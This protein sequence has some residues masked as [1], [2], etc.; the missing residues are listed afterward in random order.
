MCF[1]EKSVFLKWA[2]A[3]RPSECVGQIVVKVQQLI[4]G[5]GE[6]AGDFLVNLAEQPVFPQDITPPPLRRSLSLY[7]RVRSKQFASAGTLV[8]PGQY[9][10]AIPPL[11]ASS[12]VLPAPLLPH[13][14]RCNSSHQLLTQMHLMPEDEAQ[15]SA[16]LAYNRP[17]TVT[18]IS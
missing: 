15:S 16:F 14:I 11:L 2:R 8:R 4:R 7:L 13:R 1:L 5:A 10:A 12:S 9:C 3:D 6:G 17:H 18:G